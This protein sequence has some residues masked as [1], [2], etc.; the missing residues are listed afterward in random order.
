MGAIILI[1][2]IFQEENGIIHESCSNPKDKQRV[3]V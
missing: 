2:I 3:L 1:G